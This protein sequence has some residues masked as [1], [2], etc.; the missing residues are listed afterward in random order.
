VG[1]RGLVDPNKERGR[2]ERDERKIDKD[3]AALEKKLSSPGFVDRAP[4][5][6]VEQGRGQKKALLEAK[7]RL[8]QSK[9]IVGEL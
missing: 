5:E 8:E 1:L 9:K 4:P 6:V 3:L 2:I 7:A